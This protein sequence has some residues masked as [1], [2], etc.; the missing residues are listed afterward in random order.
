MTNIVELDREPEDT[1]IYEDAEDE[2]MPVA[3]F[4]GASDKWF[5]K[6]RHPLLPFQIGPFETAKDAFHNMKRWG[7]YA[8]DV[9]EEGFVEPNLRQGLVAMAAWDH[10]VATEVRKMLDSPDPG[11]VAL[12]QE[13]IAKYT[14]D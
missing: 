14:Y 10:T 11:V 6:I 1:Q 4:Q 3:V 5:W 8:D 7:E 9:A 12:A 2:L 13:L